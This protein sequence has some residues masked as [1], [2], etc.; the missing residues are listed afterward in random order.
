MKRLEVFGF[1]DLGST[2]SR[3]RQIVA[4]DTTSAMNL[5]LALIGLEDALKKFISE[6]PAFSLA[7]DNAEATLQALIPVL[8]A[9][10][11][12]DANRQGFKEGLNFDQQVPTWKVWDVKNKLDEFEHVLSAQCRR[13]ETYFIGQKLGFDISILLHDA[14]KN[15]H[16]SVSEYIAKEALAEIQAAGRC[17]ALESFTASGFHALR[18][19]EVVMGDYYKH[20]T[21]KNKNFRSWF[22]YVKAFKT[23]ANTRAK[24]NSPY[25]SPKVAAML[26]RMRELDRNPLM[27]PRDSLDEMAADTLF[28]L[29][30]ATITELAKDMREMAGQREMVLVADNSA[31]A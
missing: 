17:F 24:R 29:G 31:R 10:F 27:H 26:D 11:H 7:H 22:D 8:V 1:Y 18:A 30:I 15:L 6:Q 13:S 5:Y 2:V 14:G 20:V 12:P 9:E 19:L 21:G 16:E 4:P 23:L 25:P 3:F 28:K